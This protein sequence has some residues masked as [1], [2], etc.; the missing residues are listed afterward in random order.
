M[1]TPTPE[2]TTAAKA[3]VGFIVSLVMSVLTAVSQMLTEGT[4]KNVLLVVGVAV[5]AIGTGLGVYQTTNQIK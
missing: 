4:V 3:W 2:M 5:T 1:T